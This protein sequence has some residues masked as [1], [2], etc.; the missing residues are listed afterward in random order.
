MSVLAVIVLVGKKFFFLILVIKFT[1][2][3]KL[4]SEM[5][6]GHMHQGG[7]EENKGLLT[8]LTRTLS[9]ALFHLFYSKIK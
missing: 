8:N 6:H 4:S 7:R 1:H 2:A 3:R 9:S 5:R